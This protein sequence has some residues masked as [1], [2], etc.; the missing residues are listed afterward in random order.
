MK[1]KSLQPICGKFAANFLVCK[2]VRKK[3]TG[4]AANFLR[5]WCE[6]ARSLQEDVE[7]A[8]SLQE[9]FMLIS[10]VARSSQESY[11]EKVV[12]GKFAANYKLRNITPSGLY[13]SVSEPP[14]IIYTVLVIGITCNL[15]TL[16]WKIIFM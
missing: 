16:F 15:G 10:H 6:F 5:H 14:C 13:M 1:I 3:F 12:C 8:E 11:V 9:T 4:V 2:K 7:F